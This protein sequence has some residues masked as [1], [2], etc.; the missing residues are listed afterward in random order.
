MLRQTLSQLQVQRDSLRAL[1]VTSGEQKQ[2]GSKVRNKQAEGDRAAEVDGVSGHSRQVSI[3]ESEPPSHC[4]SSFSAASQEGG[5]PAL[6][7]A[8]RMHRARSRRRQLM[9]VP[10]PA[11]FQVRKEG[12]K[13]GAGEQQR[14][15]LTT[16]A[17][18]VITGAM[19]L[20]LLT[21]EAMVRTKSRV[22]WFTTRRV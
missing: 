15:A 22:L 21:A 14:T 9:P 6:F 11:G 2:R 20:T 7:A 3:G 5:A 13:E 12:R 1:A 16:V 10:T 17:L 8:Q 19:L 4:A 18:V